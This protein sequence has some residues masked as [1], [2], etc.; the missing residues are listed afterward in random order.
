MGAFRV[1]EADIPAR[2]RWIDCCM[3]TH[4]RQRHVSDFGVKWSQYN[5]R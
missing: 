4:A 2:K 3:D 5:A 1:E